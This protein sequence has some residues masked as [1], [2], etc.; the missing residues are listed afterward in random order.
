M[1]RPTAF[2][3]LLVLTSLAAL[4][5]ETFARDESGTGML[6]AT[7]E[8]IQ[9]GFDLLIPDDLKLED[10]KVRFG[11]GFGTLPDYVG[12]KNYRTKAV[13]LID[14]RY[15]RRWRLS[16][17]RLSFNA[18][19]TGRWTI[20]PFIKQ[21]SGR[22]ETRSPVLAGLSDI[23]STFQIGTFAKYKTKRMLFNAEYRH[24]LGASQGDS[25]R[26]TFGHGIFKSGRFSAAATASAKWLSGTAMQTNFGIT[27]T[28][29]LNSTAGLQVYTPRSGVSEASVSLY[30]RFQ[31]DERTR[32]VGLASYGRLLGAS[33]DS[34]LV[35]D[36]VGAVDQLK[37]GI[38]FTVDF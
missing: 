28:Q 21:K 1:A 16:N 10:L 22:R 7:I 11:A 18:I 34:P 33:A 8:N 26:V 32:L 37:L 6:N 35:A 14:I 23:D 27:T 30:G 31:I 38:G 19:L 13:P 20:G 17:R 12:A 3:N 29:S 5:N 2:K 15:G 9:D 24:A 4:S 36:S 25:L